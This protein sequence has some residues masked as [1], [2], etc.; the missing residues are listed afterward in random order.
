MSTVPFAQA[1]PAAPAPRTARLRRAVGTVAVALGAGTFGAVVAPQH[2]AAAPSDAAAPAHALSVSMHSEEER[3]TPVANACRVTEV[4]AEAPAQGR[5][6][7][8]RTLA[9]HWWSW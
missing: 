2:T 6:R 8:A 1:P 3:T 5:V 9:L 4:T 7:R